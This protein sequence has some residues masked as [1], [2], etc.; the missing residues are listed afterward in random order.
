MNGSKIDTEVTAR[1]VGEALCAGTITA[2]TWRTGMA[3][4]DGLFTEQQW[5]TSLIKLNL[6]R[7]G[8]LESLPPGAKA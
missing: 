5:F 2:L 7:S 3:S 8:Q 4:L 6:S 1:A